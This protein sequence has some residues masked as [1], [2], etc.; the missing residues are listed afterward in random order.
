MVFSDIR[1]YKAI[2]LLVSEQVCTAKQGKVITMHYFTGS[3]IINMY[4]WYIHQ[5]IVLRWC[6]HT[7]AW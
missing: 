5:Y 2:A 4:I 7:S 3:E 6:F 1:L